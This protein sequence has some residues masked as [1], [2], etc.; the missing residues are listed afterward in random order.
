[1]LGD[2]RDGC[3]RRVRA[4]RAARALQAAPSPRS[5]R[6][7]SAWRRAGRR[8]GGARFSPALRSE[9]RSPW[10]KGEGGGRGPAVGR[11]SLRGAPLW[12]FAVGGYTLTQQEQVEPAPTPPPPLPRH[13]QAQ[14]SPPPPPPAL[15]HLYP[16][17]GALEPWLPQAA[18]PAVSLASRRWAEFP[19]GWCAA[20][21][22][23]PPPAPHGPRRR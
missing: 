15:A 13:R 6:C 17:L 11:Y 3:P 12:L 10:L 23:R 16:P 18:A 9:L 7:A 5:S 2:P 19:M 20:W 14:A 8:P 1:M 21:P 4:R 22:K